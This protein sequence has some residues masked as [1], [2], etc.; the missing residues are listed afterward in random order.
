MNLIKFGLLSPIEITKYSIHEIRTE[1]SL[2]HPVF[3]ATTLNQHCLTCNGT[4]ETCEGHFGHMNLCV[5]LFHPHCLSAIIKVLQCICIHCSKLKVNRE[6]LIDKIY[7]DN[8]REQFKFVHAMCQDKKLMDDCHKSCGDHPL[9][10]ENCGLYIRTTFHNS[11]T[12]IWRGI[13]V[14]NILNKISDSDLECMGFCSRYSKPHWMILT[15][16]MVIPPIARPTVNGKLDDLTMILLDILRA[17]YKLES[18]QQRTAEDVQIKLIDNLQYHVLRY[19][20]IIDNSRHAEKSLSKRLT[21]KYGRFRY[22]LLSKRVNHCACTVVTPD[23]MIEIA[24]IG[25]PKRIA[26]TLTVP[27]HINSLN[28]NE[29]SGTPLYQNGKLVTDHSTLSNGDI[30]Q[31]NLRSNDLVLIGSKPC[32]Y[33]R[34][35]GH[36]VKVLQ[37]S[38]TFKLN[39]IL[40]TD[41]N[42]SFSGEMLRVHV[43]QSTQTTAE[44]SELMMAD[45]ISFPILNV[46]STTTV[47]DINVFLAVVTHS[48]YRIDREQMMMYINVLSDITA[49]P[50]PV[51]LK[52]RI[53]W[54][55]TQ[56]ISLLL[57]RDF[58]YFNTDTYDK[59][60]SNGCLV[61]QLTLSRGEQSVITDLARQYGNNFTLQFLS[62]LQQ[63]CI[64][65][66]THF[67][68]S[69]DLL[70]DA[71]QYF[72]LTDINEGIE[73]FMRWLEPGEKFEDRLLTTL[74]QY[75]NS[76]LHNYNEKE[77]N[78]ALSQVHSDY[79][80]KCCGLL[81]VQLMNHKL[82]PFGFSGLRP[83]PHFTVNTYN[84]DTFGF[85]C[86]SFLSGLKPH[87]FFFHAMSSV[88]STV[89]A[90]KLS[91]NTESIRRRL[92]KSMENLVVQY[93]GTVR[94]NHGN[95][96]QFK[97]GEDGINIEKCERL[98]RG[99]SERAL[100][101]QYRW[102]LLD[103][104]EDKSEEYK[105]YQQEFNQ[106][107]EYAV[108]QS[109]SKR[110]FVPF[111]LNSLIA[112]SQLL[113]KPKKFE[114][115]L[116][117]V[118]V[119]RK[120]QQ[121]LTDLEQ[122]NYLN[123]ELAMIIQCGLASKRV[124]VEYR[125]TSY[126]TLDW[127]I[128][129][130]KESIAQKQ[131]E[132]GTPVGTKS[133]NTICNGIMRSRYESIYY[134]GINTIIIDD[135]APMKSFK[136]LIDGKSTNDIATIYLNNPQ[137]VET[138]Q[139]LASQMKHTTFG[140]LVED[141]RIC[142]CPDLTKAT[143]PE[144]QYWIDMWFD[145]PEFTLDDMAPWIIRFAIKHQKDAP[146]SVSSLGRIKQVLERNYPN[147]FCLCSDD[148]NPVLILIVYV[149]KRGYS[150]SR[151]NDP[152]QLLLT[153]SEE[154]CSTWLYGI[155]GIS[156]EYVMRRYNE[157]YIRT[158]GTNLQEMLAMEAID[159]SRTR[160]NN[161]QEIERILGIEA[162]R[163]CLIKQFEQYLFT[164][165][166]RSLSLLCEHMCFSGSYR[167]IDHRTVMDPLAKCSFD[168]AA[169]RIMKS[170]IYAEQ[171]DLSSVSS[172]IITGTKV[173]IGTGI[174]ELIV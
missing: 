53:I 152:M 73:N 115:K 50:V 40:S 21:G 63:L 14:L 99:L 145:M 116:V 107:R 114:P 80:R 132:P 56:L 111:H 122:S 139:D 125:I 110:V 154:L 128:E 7:C 41:Y 12:E 131:C 58:N 10:F 68:Y 138:V 65:W 20:Q 166:S 162:A 27:I 17:N 95:I 92:I 29:F 39:P 134:P 85:I 54:S 141:I 22:N 123:D 87:E 160:S 88:N 78:K 161:I 57:P 164:V 18:Y 168:K 83:L 4:I 156:Q 170:S 81:G 28:I 69:I 169:K 104:F 121:L 74:K 15:K 47:K 126:K 61:D 165:D 100:D 120:V 77:S 147:L 36:R 32:T 172:A 153:I 135:S 143:F 113:L 49:L 23:P 71:E 90:E 25:V 46:L 31:R 72:E 101:L 127:I 98:G 118:D 13:Q 19:I 11:R 51:M 112:K 105:L 33:G 174:F 102:L 159:P 82:I 37:N 124:I 1:Q 52:P 30:V 93:D 64:I 89:E 84:K 6:C 146:Y 67:S 66:T 34:M 60:I 137:N 91:V 151:W 142:Y 42:C 70:N 155:E 79:M 136:V 9:L 75:R 130:I 140:S 3:G 45:C 24:E 35:R 59:A 150:A 144:D 163:V 119:I 109:S 16:L 106:L 94:D 133:A 62:K 43:P 26:D 55:G 8:K 173:Q 97:Y 171:D 148:N 103:L 108:N 2:F 96:I 5:P 44:L 86:N 157:W 167:A 129:C 149:K 38:S 158:K 76:A 48:T 117:A